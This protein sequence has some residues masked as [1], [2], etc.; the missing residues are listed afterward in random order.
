VPSIEHKIKQGKCFVTHRFRWMEAVFLRGGRDAMIVNWIE[1]EIVD[2]SGRVTLRNSFVTDLP[3][4]KSNVEVLAACGP[5][6]YNIENEAFNLNPAVE[7]RTVQRCLNGSLRLALLAE[8][9]D[10]SR[11][12][13]QPNGLEGGRPRCHDHRPIAPDEAQV[14]VCQKG[15]GR[16]A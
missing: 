10:R 5:A 4:D 6:R 8:V 3:V 14:L 7:Q 12:T 11:H 2:A 15:G 16:Q 13:S 1:I 9:L